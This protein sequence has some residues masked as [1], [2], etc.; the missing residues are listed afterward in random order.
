MKCGLTS[1]TF[2]KLGW[3]AVIQIARACGFDGIEWGGDI[4]VPPGEVAL[5]REVHLATVEAGLS[6]LSYG[7]Y[8]RLGGEEPFRPVLDAA[9]ALQADTIRV[10]AGAK[11]S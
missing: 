1:V 11:G 2:R 9:L 7:S 6:V 5:A 3:R 4:H 8:Y 10:W